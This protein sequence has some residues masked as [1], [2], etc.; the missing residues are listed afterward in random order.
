MAAPRA[1]GCVTVVT[2]CFQAEGRI[3]ATAASL[4]AQ[5]AVRSGRLRLEWLV[6]DGGSRDG[7]VAR[8]RE[9]AGDRATVLSEPD[10]GMWDAVAKG[11]RRAT[12]EVVGQLNAGDTYHPAALDVVADLFETGRVRWLTGVA[13][14]ANDRG[15]VVETFLPGRYRRA[16]VRKGVHGG[17][18]SRCIQQEGTFW[19]RGL[20]AGLD[21]ARLAGL[22]LAGDF[23]L[24][25]R[26]AEEADLDVVD[27]HLGTFVH[28]PG[29]L[30]EAFGAYQA[31]LRTLAEPLGPLDALLAR[32]DRWRARNAGPQRKARLDPHHLWRWDGR[33]GAWRTRR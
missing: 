14:H 33:A 8:V 24:W 11:L 27:S 26:F 20:Q 29:Q 1:V 15:Q 25:R 17:L 7:T 2:P 3:G 18:F 31:E 6:C 30:S 21:L 32:W 4:L 10:R 19:E 22:R 23:Y 28:H 9:L 16:H 12:G 13:V 5:T